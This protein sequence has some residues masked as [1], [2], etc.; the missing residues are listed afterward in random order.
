MQPL[1]QLRVA[2]RGTA[3]G[4]LETRK[5]CTFACLTIN[6]LEPARPALGTLEVVLRDLSAETDAGAR[7]EVAHGRV[8]DRAADVVE[9]DVDTGGAQRRELGVEIVADLVVPG[10]VEAELVEQP[11]EPSRRCPR[12]RRRGSRAAS[13]SVRRPSRPRRRPPR[14]RRSRRPADRRCRPGRNRP[15][16]PACP[17]RPRAAESGAVAR[18]SL[19]RSTARDDG[20]LLP[21]QHALDGVADPEGR[22]RGLEDEP[23]PRRRS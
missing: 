5:P 9:V 18:S 13:R 21:A 2:L 4:R 14:P 11:G 1:R 22:I 17:G 3:R 6:W 10:G 23:P 12:P 7:I 15:R 16:A 19:R 8:G 20:V